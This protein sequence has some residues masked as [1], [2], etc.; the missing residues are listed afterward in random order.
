M[1]ARSNIQLSQSLS[2][3]KRDDRWRLFL[4]NIKKDCFEGRYRTRQTGRRKQVSVDKPLQP[5]WE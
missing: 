3:I 2:C 5:V 4:R 1:R